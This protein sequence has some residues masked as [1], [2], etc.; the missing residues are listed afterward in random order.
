MVIGI[1]FL[2]VGID[3]YDVYEW[4]IVVYLDV[5]EWVE[6]LNMIGMS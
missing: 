1:F 4:Y 6:M 3:F 5:Y 2:I